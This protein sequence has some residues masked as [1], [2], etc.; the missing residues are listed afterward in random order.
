VTGNRIVFSLEIAM[1]NIPN[2]LLSVVQRVKDGEMPTATV[3]AFLSWFG[4]YR[5]SWR[6]VLAIRET[7]ERAEI[8][9]RPD[10]EGEYIDGTISF[11][12]PT[13]DGGMSGSP[14][15]E[16]PVGASE[17]SDVQIPLNA[18]NTMALTDTVL[19]A[20]LSVSG[21]SAGGGIST[22]SHSS[23][24]DPTQRL[25]RLKSANQKPISVHLDQSINE[26]ITLMIAHDYSQLPVVQGGRKVNGIVS[27]RSIGSLTC[28]N[29]KASTV[30]D[31]M[32]EATVLDSSTSL[33]DAIPAIIRHGSVLVRDSTGVICGIVTPSD[34]S[35]LYEQLAGPFLYLSEIENSVRVLIE[36]KLTKDDLQNAKDPADNDRVIESVADLTFGGYVRLLQNETVWNKVGLGI[37]RRVFTE[38]L[39]AVRIIRNDV[40]HFDPDGI[41]A[42]QVCTLQQFMSFLRQVRKLTSA[43]VASA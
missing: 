7:L 12:K 16:N 38:G 42:D 15:N 41:D 28:L 1:L 35:E 10:F 32:D 26:A 20:K 14:P 6:N 27:W 39:D 43:P 22:S 18:G 21:D 30:R 13:K 23:P 5:R 40:M 37:D 25:K 11:V 17:V 29:K 19:V 3:R 9:T 36:P 8:E 33:F 24:N 31:C 4:Y 2:E 34:I